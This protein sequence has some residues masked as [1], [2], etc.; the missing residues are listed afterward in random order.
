MLINCLVFSG[1]TRVFHSTSVIVID[2]QAFIESPITV[3][4]ISVKKRIAHRKRNACKQ[5]R[6]RF[7]DDFKNCLPRIFLLF[8]SY[9]V[10][11][12]AFFYI[13]FFLNVFLNLP[14]YVTVQWRVSILWIYYENLQFTFKIYGFF[15]RFTYYLSYICYDLLM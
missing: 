4:K 13:F 11:L 1:R 6:L 9:T 8:F 12:S 5:A 3:I 14:H 10:L 2:A 15:D 7:H